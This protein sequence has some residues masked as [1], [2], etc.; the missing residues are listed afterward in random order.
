MQSIEDDTAK[1]QK[2]SQGSG[3]KEVHEQTIVQLTREVQDLQQSPLWHETQVTAAEVEQLKNKFLPVMKDIEKRFEGLERTQPS[4]TKEQFE[5]LREKLLPVMEDVEKR[6]VALEL[7][8]TENASSSVTFGDEPPL[9]PMTT[10]IERIQILESKESSLEPSLSTLHSSI[11]STPWDPP[12]GA[13]KEDGPSID[14]TSSIQDQPLQKRV[15]NLEVNTQELPNRQRELESKMDKLLRSDELPSFGKSTT[16]RSCKQIKN[17][18]ES[19][20]VKPG[21]SLG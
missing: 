5:K 2:V 13:K 14:P 20:G 7:R 4:L 8:P 3:S 12:E 15:E 16:I 10:I 19:N 11:S 6:L 17:E 21:I 9:T 1:L 18:V